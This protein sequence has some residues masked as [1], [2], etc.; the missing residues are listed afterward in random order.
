MRKE[1]KLLLWLMAEKCSSSIYTLLRNIPTKSEDCCTSWTRL[2]GLI[3]LNSRLLVWCY[4][5][6]SF[7]SQT[8][9][10]QALK[11]T[12]AESQPLCHYSAFILQ[13]VICDFGLYVAEW[14]WWTN[15]LEMRWRSLLLTLNITYGQIV[16]MVSYTINLCARGLLYIFFIKD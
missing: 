3:Q 5:Q 11:T 12:S 16:S 15:R 4:L 8:Y 14:L 2:K 1:S 7:I 13:E 9:L 10:I 6:C